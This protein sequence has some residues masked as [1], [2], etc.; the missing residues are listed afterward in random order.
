MN[1]YKLAPNGLNPN[2][3][4]YSDQVQARTLSGYNAKSAQ[5]V[6]DKDSQG[7][8][9][10]LGKQDVGAPE[11]NV[12]M[13]R[14][15]TDPMFK[16]RNARMVLE[17]NA[18][19][20]N[21]AIST[22]GTETSYTSTTVKHRFGTH[23]TNS[24]L[25]MA[26]T[27]IKGSDGTTVTE[28]RTVLTPT[29]LVGGAATILGV[30]ASSTVFECPTEVSLQTPQ[31]QLKAP[32]YAEMVRRGLNHNAPDDT[33][34]IDGYKDYVGGV[35]IAGSVQVSNDASVRMGP[36]NGTF[37]LASNGFVGLGTS[38]PTTPLDIV[39]D[40]HAT[41][42]ATVDVSLTTPIVYTNNIEGGTQPILI[43]TTQPITLD[44][45]KVNFTGEVQY[46]NVSSANFDV[47]TIHLAQQEVYQ[48]IPIYHTAPGT[49]DMH[50]TDPNVP[51]LV[52]EFEKYGFF[53]ISG[54]RRVDGAKTYVK[55]RFNIVSQ[56]E[57]IDGTQRTITVSYTPTD[58]F[59][60]NTTATFSFLIAED[61]AL[62]GAG[63]VVDNV[64]DNLPS[65]ESADDYKQT[66][67]WYH[68]QGVF[69]P[70]GTKTADTAI[71]RPRWE[72]T[73][74]H[75]LM[76]KSARLGY[77]FAISD[78]GDFNLYKIYLDT[79]GVEQAELVGTF[80]SP[81]A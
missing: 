30:K 3:T 2:G 4:Y 56:T 44:A 8:Q 50:A 28:S 18:D 32:S 60:A 53:M 47:K 20:S 40:L 6:F 69:N 65:A 41:G 38:T 31:V 7:L 79:N 35:N 27:D 43:R 77:E 61:S 25:D 22:T 81:G 76:R 14:A 73:G 46:V 29:S 57:V 1:P 26:L 5:L 16:T 78:A 11:T 80:Y 67:Q 12:F 34:W 52:L 75:L 17:T 58:Q 70:N 48:N 54:I 71:A 59:R 51:E 39:G 63:F 33:L 36:N 10:Q 45:P 68:K 13:S 55:E 42:A 23:I 72:L 19:G 24:Y 21:V 64:I 37:F 49:F 15:G 66:F 74:G 9:I 62:D